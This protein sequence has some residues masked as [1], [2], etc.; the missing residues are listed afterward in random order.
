MQRVANHRFLFRRG[1]VYYFR[2][3]VPAEAQS[4]FGG[5]PVVTTSLQTSSLAEARSTLSKH[6]DAFEQ[7]VAAAR[8]KPDPT[9]HAKTI[10]P[11]SHEP[12]REEVDEVVRA[13]LRSREREGLH[14]EL[15]RGDAPEEVVQEL[16]QM[17]DGIKLAMQARH[18]S[19]Q[20]QTAW[21]ADHLA[22]RHGWIVPE[23][24]PIRDYVVRMIA[25]AELE[26][27]SIVKSEVLFDE[28]PVPT[29]IFSPALYQL[30]ADRAERKGRHRPVSIMSLFDD[31]CAEA[32]NSPAT[33]KAWKTCLQSLVDHLGHDDATKVSKADI[34]GWKD[35]LLNPTDGKKARSHNT[36]SKK[37][38]AATKTVF[39]WAERNDKLASNPAAT[40]SIMIPKKMRLRDEPGLTDLEA[41]AILT[42]ASKAEPDRKPLRGFGR[43]WIPWLCAYTGARVGEI[44]QLRAQDVFK[45][46]DG[47]W[48]IR[49]TPEAGS[50]KA[51]RAREVPLHPHLIE[52]GFLKAIKGRAGPLFYDPGE[53]RGGSEGNPQHKKVAER[54]AGWVRDLGVSHPELQPNHGWRHRFK[55]VARSVRMDHEVR[56][57]IQGHAAR[58][59]GDKYGGTAMRLRYEEIC[60]LPHY[61]IKAD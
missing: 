46:D 54:L 39:G 9:R 42:A 50:Q 13:W 6:L 56:D 3:A 37:Y 52:Q 10:K 32:R 14:A 20:L 22:E 7:V 59:E 30:D 33:V 26:W 55:R 25:R 21:I 16:D 43:R 18:L 36:I 28:R 49:I 2:R 17:R 57:N 58:T 24:S 40:V 61:K 19:P 51:N 15:G 12:T 4:A 48:C 23:G 53:H 29:G 1:Q 41:L 11:L 35:A 45:H 38:L 47:I 8:A 27:A 34:V 31:Y 60:K 44:T 5:K